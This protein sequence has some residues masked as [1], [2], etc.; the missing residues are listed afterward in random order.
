LNF[1]KNKPL[2]IT[3]IVIIILVLLMASTASSSTI[4]RGATVAGGAF[5]PLQTFFYQIS[6]SIRNTFSPS[7]ALSGEERNALTA[8]LDEYKVKLMDYE[9]LVA[10]N[11]RLS[12]MLEYKQNNENRELK[13]ARITGK[14]PGNWFDVFT[15]DLGANDGVEKNMAVVTPDGLVGR[16]EEVG[17]NWSKVMAAIDSR[18]S[19]PVIVERTRDVGVAGGS[20]GGD[21]LSRTLSMNYLPFDSD[22]VEGDVVVTSG[23]GG[24]FP[25]GLV[26]GT[27]TE[28]RTSDGGMNVTV[29][30]SV[31]FRRLEE[32]M[33]IIDSED[34]TNVVADNIS[35]PSAAT[36]SSADETGSGPSSE[37][38]AVPEEDVVG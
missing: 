30:P 37:P 24:I 25:K 7:D 38:S 18:S 23:L 29:E 13:L 5:V 31:D 28:S 20:I 14:D 21:E 26:V 16:V 2:I 9:E 34:T 33:V 17:L 19:I 1:A 8:E 4:S 12:E 27:V 15:I 36:I 22:I 32:V 10:E 3:I 35:D 11:T 6:D